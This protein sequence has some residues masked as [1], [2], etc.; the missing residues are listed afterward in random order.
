MPQVEVGEAIRLILSQV[1]HDP[2][3]P[4]PE[5]D[6]VE[7]LGWLE[8]PLDDAP[9][10][11]VT[12]INEGLVPSSLTADLFLPNRLRHALGIEDNDRRYARDLYAI[13]VL[14]ASR[15]E[16]KLIAGR[17]SPEGD[18]LIPSRL[19]M[20]I[21][22]PKLAERV[23]RF[24]C[25]RFRRRRGQIRKEST[26]LPGQLQTMR[27]E[28]EFA[29]PQP[30]RLASPVRSMRVTE[31][32]DY[33]ACPYRYYLRHRLKLEPLRDDRIELDGAAFGSLAHEVLDR[34]GKSEAVNTNDPEAIQEFLDA[35]LDSLLR[36]M[37]GKTPPAVVLIQQEQL[38]HRLHR[39]A[40]WQADRFSEGW[41]VEYV[42]IGV[43][44][45]GSEPCRGW[46]P[47]V[48]AR[49]YRPDRPERT[50]RSADD[51]RLQDVRFGPLA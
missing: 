27:H 18:P 51:P 35:E 48:S 49:A 2:I 16:L 29:V 43:T 5:A 39:F 36:E 8:L 42:E 44:G 45:E 26:P 12:G 30:E 6:A 33:L 23:L 34:L 10:L 24:F 22:G 9:V 50:N 7:M 31:F 19:L 21:E 28:S 4:P 32:R 17:R 11:I 37:V 40:Q 41:R 15:S 13:S 20:S 47:H 3:A 25:R 38:R 46:D 14:A 1:A